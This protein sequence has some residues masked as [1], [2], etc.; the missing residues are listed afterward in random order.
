MTNFQQVKLKELGEVF[1]LVHNLGYPVMLGRHLRAEREMYERTAILVLVSW[2]EI[3][4][5]VRSYIPVKKI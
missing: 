2:K 3:L 5:H 4:A 1:K